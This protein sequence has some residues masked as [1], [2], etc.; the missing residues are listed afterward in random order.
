MADNLTGAGWTLFDLRALRKNIHSIGSAELRRVILG[1]DLLLVI[2]EAK[3][4]A[5]IR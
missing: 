3:P 4:A 2:P 1:F 5:Q